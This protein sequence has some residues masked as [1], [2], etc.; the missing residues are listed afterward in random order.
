MNNELKELLA[1]K[2]L[3]LLEAGE[4][5]EQGRFTFMNYLVTV[6]ELALEIQTILDKVEFMN[7]H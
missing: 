4:D 1:E 7:K 6:K 5:F 2:T 3:K